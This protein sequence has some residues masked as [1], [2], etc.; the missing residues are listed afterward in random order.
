MK[1]TFLTFFVLICL[2]LS[3]AINHK[4]DQE[5]ISTFNAF[6]QD[7]RDANLAKA[8]AK[9]PFIAQLP[10]ESRLLALN[11]FK[12]IADVKPYDM[13]K[14]VLRDQNGGYLLVI[15]LNENESNINVP[16][17]KGK[18]GKWEIGPAVQAIQHIDFVPAK[19]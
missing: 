2:S 9:A 17:T 18:A 4:P 6:L 14:K 7:I 16:F 15:T 13:K 10:E 5:I 12:I 3:C 19:K 1:K 11:S 8:E